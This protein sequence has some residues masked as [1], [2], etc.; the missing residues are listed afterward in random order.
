MGQE[1]FV[2]ARTL[3]GEAVNPVLFYFLASVLPYLCFHAPVLHH[4]LL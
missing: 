1:F 2:P 3:M 4:V